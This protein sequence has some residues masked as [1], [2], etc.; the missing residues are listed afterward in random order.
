MVQPT[1]DEA[2]GEQHRPAHA[3]VQPKQPTTAELQFLQSGTGKLYH[4]EV[5]VHERAPG[6]MG[7]PKV[8]LGKIAPLEPAVLI[9]MAAQV[10]S[11]HVLANEMLPMILTHDAKF[12]VPRDPALMPPSAPGA[13]LPLHSIL[14]TADT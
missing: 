5:A 14:S 12:V 3:Q 9:A 2:G 4:G 1:I 7:A 10:P 8:R 6:Q 11:A 13:F